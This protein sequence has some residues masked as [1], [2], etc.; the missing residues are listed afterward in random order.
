MASPQKQSAYESL[1]MVARNSGRRSAAS[2]SVGAPGDAL[3][4]TVQS[5]RSTASNSHTSRRP[6]A[7]RGGPY[8]QRPGSVQG[9]SEYVNEGVANG[10]LRA[11]MG[12]GIVHHARKT[13]PRASS[14]DNASRSTS[15]ENASRSTPVT[16][17]LS[18]GR[19]ATDLRDYATSPNRIG[20]GAR[21]NGNAPPQQQL[22][23]SLKP[24]PSASQEPNKASRAHSSPQHRYMN[25]AQQQQR[26]AAQDPASQTLPTQPVHTMPLNQIQHVY[27]NSGDLRVQTSENAGKPSKRS[28]RDPDFYVLYRFKRPRD[29]SESDQRV[30]VKPATIKVDL[31]DGAN[32]TPSVRL[33]SREVEPPPPPP[34]PLPLVD[35]ESVDPAK[36]TRATKASKPRSAPQKQLVSRGCWAA[37]PLKVDASFQVDPLYGPAG[38]GAW[39]SI[40]YTPLLTLQRGRPTQSARPNGTAPNGSPNGYPLKSALKKTGSTGGP[41]T[42]RDTLPP[43]LQGRLGP[44]VEDASVLVLPPNA[45]PEEH[46][47]DDVGTESEPFTGALPTKRTS[48]VNKWDLVDEGVQVKPET[49]TQYAQDAPPRDE[50]EVV[51]GITCGPAGETWPARR[52][53]CCQTNAPAAPKVKLFR[54]FAP[55][56]RTSPSGL[57]PGSS[58]GDEL[59][60]V[61]KSEKTM[62]R[63]GSLRIDVSPRIKRVM[64]P[65]RLLPARP[66]FRIGP[67]LVS[68]PDVQHWPP[69]DGI[70]NDDEKHPSQTPSTVYVRQRPTVAPPTCDRA[71]QARARD[72]L[73]QYR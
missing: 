21:P 42:A 17:Q 69:F 71:T 70:P 27:S 73:V 64:S 63:S 59:L 14:R 24:S 56:Q 67:P 48:G 32:G 39:R 20:G 38:Q 10:S 23:A 37:G 28:P 22:S 34:P 25:F 43:L 66:E 15:K 8:Q 61:T 31:P 58:L 7:A 36:K 29:Q 41:A 18:V 46:P 13:G 33:E 57:R 30:A 19:P 5:Q 26:L 60:P 12:P 51:S 6:V 65:R 68:R 11:A 53:A 16:E 4:S 35:L 44:Q 1:L 50:V 52:D 55:G 54:Q 3:G 62:R 9:R 2:G 72:I 40:P 49:S 47:F 45:G